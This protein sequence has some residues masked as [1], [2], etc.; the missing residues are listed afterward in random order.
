ADGNTLTVVGLGGRQKMRDL[1][2]GVYRLHDGAGEISASFNRVHVKSMDLGDAYDLLYDVTGGRALIDNATGYS[3]LAANDNIVKIEGSRAFSAFSG[4]IERVSGAEAFD[5]EASRNYLEIIDSVFGGIV[6]AGQASMFS[7]FA[8]AVDNTVI[9][10][11]DSS[12]ASSLYGGQ[13]RHGEAA[14][15]FF[16]GNS[17]HVELPKIGGIDVRCNVGNFEK[18]YFLFAA[19][20]PSGS[21]GLKVAGEFRL[22]DNDNGSYLGARG[23][24]VESVDLVG[25]VVPQA[26]HEFVLVEGTV[27]DDNFQQTTAT[28]LF[29]VNLLLDYDLR[30][31]PDRLSAVFKGARSHP[32]MESLSEGQSAGLSLANLG[33]DLIS[34][35]G[36]SAAVARTFPE[37]CPAA[38]VSAGGGQFR[39][40]TGSFYDVKAFYGL[41]GVDCLTYLDSGALNLGAF[42]EGGKGDYRAEATYSGNLHVQ[43][44]GDMEYFGLGLLGSFELDSISV[45]QWRLESSLRFGRMKLGYGSFDFANSDAREVKYETSAPYFGGHVGVDRQFSLSDEAGLDVYAK[46][47]FTRLEGDDVII[48]DKV[49]VSF[50][51][52]SSHR[53]RVGARLSRNVGVMAKFQFGMGFEQEFDGLS[54]ASTQGFPIE[55]PSVKGGVGLA[56][57]G[58]VFRRGGVSPLSFGLNL[59]GFAGRREGYAGSVQ[60]TLEF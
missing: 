14:N 24:R 59:E 13:G 12:F 26:G 28:G 22:N 23:A 38:F 10:R 56:E 53:V 31:E 11:G 52:A 45:G 50:E 39:Y 29:N 51:A 54:R 4:T 57:V 1:H 20:A 41:I 19:D 33:L 18:Y 21:V 44:R 16:A 32:Q 27:D 58:L 7:R 30:V 47:L 43:G 34:G 9:V 37:P 35:Q 3:F 49:P 36:V 2:G 15:D 60:V 17:L 5:A 42:V 46:Y 55:E 48:L 8:R 40:D 25:G 6:V